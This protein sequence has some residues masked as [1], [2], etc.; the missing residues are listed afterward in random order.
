MLVTP[1][2]SELRNIAEEG[3][4]GPAI[5]NIN[6][7]RPYELIEGAEQAGPDSDRRGETQLKPL[8]R[9]AVYA[10]Y[11]P[12]RTHCPYCG[13]KL[14]CQ[15][16]KKRTKIYGLHADHYCK[17]YIMVCKNP[18]CTKRY[19]ITPQGEKKLRTYTSQ[20]FKRLAVPRHRITWRLLKEIGRLRFEERLGL[21]QIQYLLQ[22]QYALTLPITRLSDWSDLYE[23][24]CLAWWTKHPAQIHQA[25]DQLNE[26]IY[27]IDYTEDT[28][29][30]PVIRVFVAGLGLGLVTRVVEKPKGDAVQPILQELQDRYDSPG[31]IVCD[32]DATIKAACRKVW[33]DGPIQTCL[34]HLL[35]NLAKTFLGPPRQAVYSRGC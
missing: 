34:E 1:L 7:K 5:T 12:K 3:K 9:K 19:R 8:E 21:A 13:K 10:E 24:A 20:D 33:P 27:L 15:Y 17:L 25:L 28:T 30:Q 6:K 18:A 26:R 23:A 29:K 35:R 32:D 2:G 14:S 31:L 22:H 16:T 11:K 4:I